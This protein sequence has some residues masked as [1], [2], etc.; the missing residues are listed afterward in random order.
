[1][2]KGIGIDKKEFNRIFKKFYRVKNRF[3]QQGSIGLGLAF[4]K[5]IVDFMG[6]D[7]RVDSV[8]EQGTTFTIHLPL[9]PKKT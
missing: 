8:P 5:G 9:G 4:C 1:V 2:D 3:N 7:I 6:G